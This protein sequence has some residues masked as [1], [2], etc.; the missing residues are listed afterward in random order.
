MGKFISSCRKYDS[1]KVQIVSLGAGLDARFFNL[2]VAFLSFWYT[3]C[4]RTKLIILQYEGNLRY[5]EMDY[6]AVTRSKIKYIE[7]SSELKNKIGEYTRSKI[8][9]ALSFNRCIL[10]CCTTDPSCT[11]LES[12]KYVLLPGDLSEFR[13]K[14]LSKLKG[15]GLDPNSPVLYILEC[16]LIYISKEEVYDILQC[17]S[18][19]SKCSMMII[20]EYFG[21]GSD[22]FSTSMINDLKVVSMHCTIRY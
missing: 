22:P 1:D 11:C 15:S 7:S 8:L 21:L 20:Y 13:D 12:E 16:I 18:E 17:L 5:Y 10:S 2:E 14:C 9:H 19:F 3:V 6:D 4:V